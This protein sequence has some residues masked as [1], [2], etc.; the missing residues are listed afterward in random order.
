M[1]VEGPAPLDLGRQLR[2][3]ALSVADVGKLCL[4]GLDGRTG[5]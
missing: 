1:F 4:Q 5:S 2:L 3:D